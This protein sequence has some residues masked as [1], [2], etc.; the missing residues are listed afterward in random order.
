VLGEE[1]EQAGEWRQLSL[2]RNIRK[3]IEVKGRKK[4]GCSCAAGSFFWNEKVLARPAFLKARIVPGQPGLMGG[5]PTVEIGRL[6]SS[7]RA[8]GAAV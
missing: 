2:L 6:C 4:P 1:V 5:F 3:S 8:S 7:L